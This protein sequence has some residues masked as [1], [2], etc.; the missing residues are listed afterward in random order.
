MPRSSSNFRQGEILLLELPFTDYLG[1][2]LRPVLV[3]SSDELN[4]VSDD[5]IV[6]KITGS[7]HFEE[8]PVELEQKDL[9]RGKLKKKSFIDCS[10]VFT[11]EK[12]LIIKSIGEIGPEKMD[13][14][15]E[16]LKRTF[17]IG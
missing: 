2:K 15:K 13:E 12:S 8:F 16:I 10:S 4:K 6:L 1:K 11:V 3:V 7:P 14:V 9:L 17:S 5:L